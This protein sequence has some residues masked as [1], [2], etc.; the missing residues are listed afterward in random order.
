MDGL[1]QRPA[2]TA[3]QAR[4]D[5]LD[6]LRGVAICGIL[7][8]NIP[9]MGGIPA[10]GGPR[11]PAAWNADWIVAGVQTILFEG[12]MRGLFTLLFGA[13]ML[14]MLRRA[15]GADPRPEP[16]DVWTRRCLA[17]MGLG[18]VQ[19]AIFLWPGEILWTYGLTGLALL[20][21]RTA[22]IRSLLIAAAILIVGLTG[23]YLIQNTEQIATLRAS[24]PAAAAQAA[25]RDLSE[26]QEDALDAVEE[27]RKV[28]H[29]TAHEIAAEYEQR[30]H[31]LPLVGWST[32]LWAEWNLGTEQW[33]WLAESLA[34]MLVGMALYRSGILTGQAPTRTYAQLAAIGYGVG[35][36]LRAILFAWQAQ[37]GF[38]GPP[39]SPDA[40][41]IYY[42]QLIEQ[43]A[44]L[45]ITLGHVGGV[46]LLV[47]A[48]ALGRAWTLRALGR[49]AL[50]VYSLQSI[51]TSVLFYGFGTVGRFGFATLEAIAVAIWIVTAAFALWWL[52]HFEIG[53]A[54]W[55]LRAIA[56][57]DRTR[58]LRKAA[59]LP[60]L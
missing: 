18:I 19:F 41:M 21:F 34:F 53:P 60:A 49:M 7:L 59:A 4:I 48:G 36:P 45:L 3:A 30:T 43:P 55:L 50:T 56:Y 32:E 44:R 5:T 22:R 54:E 2:P 42:E 52:R 23:W 57:G 1:G 20:A 17:L 14:L 51:L 38:D 10:L 11:L 35:L 47:R 37:S 58:P 29:P 9:I 39:G 46:I 12:T 26:G 15:E 33:P 8:M 25:G 28:R 24:V 16:I 31:L 27:I 40:A 13:G 6:I